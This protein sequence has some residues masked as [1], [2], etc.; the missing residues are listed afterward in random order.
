MKPIGVAD[1]M[2]RRGAPGCSAYDG[3]ETVYV[4]S[5]DKAFYVKSAAEALVTQAV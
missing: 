3:C 5:H 4:S 2:K 1:L